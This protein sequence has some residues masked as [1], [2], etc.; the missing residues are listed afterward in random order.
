MCFAT[1][2]EAANARGIVALGSPEYEALLQQT[3]AAASVPANQRPESLPRRAKGETLLDFVLRLM[4]EYGVDR[5]PEP[6]L[7]ESR[8]GDPSTLESKKPTSTSQTTLS[9]VDLVVSLLSELEISE[10]ERLY[11][12]DKNALVEVLSV[13]LAG[14]K[15]A[16]GV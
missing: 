12:E 10:L 5:P 15:P 2:A 6:I 8:E 1:Y 7:T 11:A 14:P 4:T 3:E 9:M 16:G 13:R